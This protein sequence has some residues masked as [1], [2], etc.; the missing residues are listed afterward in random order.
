MSKCQ[1]FAQSGRPASITAEGVNF[2][3]GISDTTPAILLHTS[4]SLQS[5]LFQII[6][7][8]INLLRGAAVVTFKCPIYPTQLCECWRVC[9]VLLPLTKFQGLI[10]NM[11]LKCV[12]WLSLYLS[13]F[14]KKLVQTRHAISVP[15][16]TAGRGNTTYQAD[17]AAGLDGFYVVPLNTILLSALVYLRFCIFRNNTS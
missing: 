8:Y 2:R 5:T 15:I 1:K 9:T 12:Y 3:V 6:C 13:F 10:K 14:L 7:T 11:Q 17:H 16:S 4:N